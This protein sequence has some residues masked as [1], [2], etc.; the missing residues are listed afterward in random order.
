MNF[1]RHPPFTAQ[2]FTGAVGQ[3]LVHIHI[4]LG[5]GAGLPDSQRELLRVLSGEDFVSG[6]DDRP[7][8]L[9]RQ[10]PEILINLRRRPLGQRQG[11]NQLPGHFF[12]R[13]AEMLQ[14]ALGL[15]APEFIGRDVD[16]AHRVFFTAMRCH[17]F[18]LGFKVRHSDKAHLLKRLSI[19]QIYKLFWWF[20]PRS[21]IKKPPEGRPRPLTKCNRR[22]CPAALRLCGP[23]EN[24]L[25]V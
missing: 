10:Q 25:T 11:V 14:R 8:F 24:C 9:R 16:G 2:Q 7:G 15:G 6:S 12:G 4:A 20:V 22:D 5:A 17:Y 3:H 19:G 23:T 21:D 1:S 13:D 18:L